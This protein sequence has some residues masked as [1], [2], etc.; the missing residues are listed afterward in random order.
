MKC[1]ETDSTVM[2][3]VSFF[4]GPPAYLEQTKAAGDN[5]SQ[6]YTQ[7]H[8]DKDDQGNLTKLHKKIQIIHVS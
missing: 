7:G 2:S 5:E 6:D 8:D 4:V 3:E 1:K